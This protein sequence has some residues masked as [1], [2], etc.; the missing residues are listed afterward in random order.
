MDHREKAGGRSMIPIIDDE[1]QLKSKKEESPPKCEHTRSS[2]LES[3]PTLH[4]VRR[5]V[6]FTKFKKEP[7]WCI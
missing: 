6:V 3:L 4:S 2:S 7:A 1:A 5:V